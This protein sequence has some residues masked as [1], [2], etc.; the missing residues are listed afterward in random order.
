MTLKSW[1]FG[2]EMDRKM[3][4]Q[5]NFM[6]NLRIS[7]HSFQSSSKIVPSIMIVMFVFSACYYDNEETL[8]PGTCNVN[9]VTY[10]GYIKP[11]LDANCTC[12]LKGSLNGNINLEGYVEVKKYVNDGRLIKVINHESG[13]SP[14]PPAVPKRNSCD[15]SKIQAWVRTGALNN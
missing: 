14:M 5:L 3:I 15:L 7:N 13:V 6:K 8:Y 2:L 1:K 4:K 12:H 10:A 9:D 11:F